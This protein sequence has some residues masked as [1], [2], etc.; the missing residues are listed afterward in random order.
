MRGQA[1]HALQ[2]EPHKPQNGLG[3]LHMCRGAHHLGWSLR[4]GP[5]VAGRLQIRQCPTGGRC[6]LRHTLLPSSAVVAAW[7]CQWALEGAAIAARALRPVRL[8]ADTDPVRGGEAAVVVWLR[9]ERFGRG[10]AGHQLTVSKF[11]ASNPSVVSE[12]SFLGC[13][14]WSGRHGWASGR[15]ENRRSAGAESRRLRKQ[16]WG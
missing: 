10:V 8:A 13:P 11:A 2:E 4:D 9:S 14:L 12:P 1:L 6:W 3:A 16:V 5:L 15:R 7:A